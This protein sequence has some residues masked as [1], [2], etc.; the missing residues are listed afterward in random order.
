MIEESAL[1][2]RV[3]L[4]SLHKDAMSIMGWTDEATWAWIGTPCEELGLVSPA[5]L[6]LK[7]EHDKIDGFLLGMKM[8]LSNTNNSTGD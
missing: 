2:S 3:K 5:E 8:A 6:I 1:D 4:M 7:G